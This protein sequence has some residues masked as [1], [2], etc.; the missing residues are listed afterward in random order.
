MIEHFGQQLI[1][2]YAQQ[3]K[4]SRSRVA[5]LKEI[6]ARFHEWN[7]VNSLPLTTTCARR[8]TALGV[9]QLTDI[10]CIAMI[11]DRLRPSKNH[12]QVR[13]IETT[14]LLKRVRFADRQPAIAM[15]ATSTPLP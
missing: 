5:M 14:N 1:D 3:G 7:D 8:C 13:L 15:L 9:Q 12:P 10:E 11:L 2:E 6:Y 4:L